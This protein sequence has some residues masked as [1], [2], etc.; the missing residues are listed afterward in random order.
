VDRRR[1]VAHLAACTATGGVLAA[2][3]GAA[4]TSGAD[5]TPARAPVTIEV[6]TRAG[7]GNPTGH[8][9]YY[10]TIT[11]QLF[12]PETSITV[13]FIDAEPDVAQKLIVLAA[14][15]TLPDGSWYGVI[16]DGQGGPP[17]AMNGIYK[18]LDEWVK[19]DAR[20]DIKP[21]FPALLDA[22]SLKGKLYALP[23]HGHYGQNVLYYNAP[24]VDAAGIT[25]PKDGSWTIDQLLA[26]AQ[27]LVRK[28]EG[29]WGF[30]PDNAAAANESTPFW[31]RLFGGEML[32]ET[33]TKCLLDSAQCR[34]AFEWVAG[35]QHKAG[36]IDDLF[37]SGGATALFQPGK[38]AFYNSNAAGVATLRK[39][40][41]ELIRFELGTAIF[42][43]GPTGKLSSQVSG[44]GM[45]IVGTTKQQATWEWIKFITSKEVG[46]LGM[47][48]GGA[49]N[50]GG[51]SDVYNDP[52]LAAWDPLFPTLLKAYPQGPDTMRRPANHRRAD[53]N[54]IVTEE[55]RPY[56]EGKAGL[57]EA[58]ART[59]QRANALL[60]QQP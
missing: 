16:G 9:Q 8:S 53:F 1:A 4:S 35:C 18:P 43:R 49:G 60:A 29:L 52:R 3:G 54:A 15:G 28:D 6:L 10:N 42:P 48:S 12:T 55:L 33:G 40:G 51:R 41:Q 19:K 20:F 23:V 58:T 13:R 7:V 59:V 17:G 57:N 47:I 32:D 44:S 25:V 37:R 56:L 26:A 21:Y 34:T 11:P 45:G 5:P 22:F 2:C 24:L 31:V 38:L 50:A 14:G 30:L 27:K 39:P 46:V 36:V